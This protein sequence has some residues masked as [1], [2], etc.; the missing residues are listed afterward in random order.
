MLGV[1]GRRPR[2]GIAGRLVS[3]VMGRWKGVHTPG[4]EAFGGFELYD[5]E[6][7]PGER[8][9]LVEDP[10]PEAGW[11]VMRRWLEEW[12]GVAAG[13]GGVGGCGAP[14]GGG[15]EGPGGGDASASGAGGLHS[16]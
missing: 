3:V 11:E 13:A 9:N 2:E 6:G 8:R 5:L 16:W 7:D 14:G 12:G 15:E 1:H 10:P 4:V